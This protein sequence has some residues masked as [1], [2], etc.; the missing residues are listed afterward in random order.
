MRIGLAGYIYTCCTFLVPNLYLIVYYKEAQN[1]QIE[2]P[3]QI[4]SL[5]S[6]QN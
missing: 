2:I 4:K 3:K 5:H 6:Q 1:V